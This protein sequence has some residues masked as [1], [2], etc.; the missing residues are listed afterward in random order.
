MA[1]LLPTDD[2]EEKQ[3][4]QQV[5]FTGAPAASTFGGSAPQQQAQPKGT[6][7]VN[8]DRWVGANQGQIGT[9]IQN[10]GAKLLGEEKDAFGKAADPL[11]MAEF[12][13]QKLSENDVA[14]KVQSG[15][16]DAL[17]GALQQKY[18]GP[19]ELNYDPKKRDGVKGLMNLSS[20]DTASEVV[21]ANAIKQG[22]YGG[23][24]RRLDTALF[25]GSDEGRNAIG[26]VKTGAEAFSKDVSTEANGL[27][28]KIQGF[29]KAA[30]EGRET[31]AKSMQAFAD[32][33]IKT[34]SD[35]AKAINAQWRN[36]Q[37]SGTVR[38]PNTRRVGAWPRRQRE[39]P[40]DRGRRR[41]ARQARRAAW[42]RCAKA[43]RS[44]V[45][46]RRLLVDE[47]DRGAGDDRANETAGLRRPGRWCEPRRVEELERTRLERS[48][49][50]G[51]GAL[52]RRGRWQHRGCSSRRRLWVARVGVRADRHG[53][54]ATQHRRLCIAATRDAVCDRR[55]HAA[56]L[57]LQRS[58][59]PGDA[60][61]DAA[62][63]VGETASAV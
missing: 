42:I 44:T 19:R 60:R 59:A 40:D 11:K 51:H 50:R 63:S 56:R 9:N 15:Q 33:K 2:E 20:A 58:Q 4:Q 53:Q 6:G 41:S 24:L 32:N 21:A 45:Q 55:L 49:N 28:D 14:Q 43:R 31:S 57:W 36:D 12:N 26:G 8:F 5:P 18:E 1:Q 39:Q 30:E 25:G 52:W 37:V 17:S 48:S 22:Q 34:L 27:F 3:Q 38:D 16:W 7:F 13:A 23:G 47:Q 54:S 29:D 35:K 10:A 61:R 62:G 46:R